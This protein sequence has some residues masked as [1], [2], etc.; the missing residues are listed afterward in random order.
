ML[1]SH[2]IGSVDI[3]TYDSLSEND[4]DTVYISNVYFHNDLNV[5]MGGGNDLLN[6]NQSY[7]FGSISLDTGAGND[8]A[9]LDVVTAVDHFMANLGDGNDNLTMGLMWAHDMRLL[10]GNGLDQLNKTNTWNS[11]SIFRNGWESGNGLG[12]LPFF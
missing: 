6:V 12:W 8:T 4:A 2:D 3:Q 7:A 11:P 10:G 9:K 5:R 1:D